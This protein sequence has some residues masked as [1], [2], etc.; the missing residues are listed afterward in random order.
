MDNNEQKQPAQARPEKIIDEFP[1]IIGTGE[2]D[3]NPDYSRYE[4]D[5][6]FSIYKVG[7]E[8]KST[9]LESKEKPLDFNDPNAFLIQTD[10]SKGGDNQH[11]VDLDF[12]LNQSPKATSKPTV[13]SDPTVSSAQSATA[14]EAAFTKETFAKNL[15]YAGDFSFSEDLKSSENIFDEK[16]DLVADMSA[17]IVSENS[18]FS[19]NILDLSASNVVESK[20]PVTL[21][22][23]NISFFLAEDSDLSTPTISNSQSIENSVINSSSLVS[24]ADETKI[25]VAPM[26]DDLHVSSSSTQRPDDNVSHDSLS[27][28]LD[29]YD[30]GDSPAPKKHSSVLDQD[31][32]DYVSESHFEANIAQPH[33]EQPEE[34]ILSKY[35][36]TSLIPSTIPE[37]EVVEEISTSFSAPVF[38]EKFPQALQ[39][40]QVTLSD[41]NH[42][43]DHEVDNTSHLIDSTGDIMKIK[44]QNELWNI[45]D[46]YAASADAIEHASVPLSSGEP[47][48]TEAKTIDVQ[49]QF[50]QEFVI[51]PSPAQQFK[52]ES[53]VEPKRQSLSDE[54]SAFQN[55]SAI[56]DQLYAASEEAPILATAPVMS[57]FAVP[58]KVQNIPDLKSASFDSFANMPAADQYLEDNLVEQKVDSPFAATN[59][60]SSNTLP[61]ET[62][63]VFTE[64]PV[65]AVDIKA[66]Q[67][68]YSDST[69]ADQPVAI[70][71]VLEEEEPPSPTSPPSA[72]TAVSYQVD[73]SEPSSQQ[74]HNSPQQQQQTQP[75]QL[76]EDLISASSSTNL[77]HTSSPANV[78]DQQQQVLS[79]LKEEEAEEEELPLPVQQ[80]QEKKSWSQDKAEASASV[81][82]A[83]TSA[84]V[85]SAVTAEK[86]ANTPE[87]KWSSSSAHTTAAAATT[88]TTNVEPNTRPSL[89]LSSSP[90]PD[91]TSSTSKMGRKNN[92]F[93]R[94]NSNDEPEYS[95][96]GKCFLAPSLLALLL[97]S[98]VSLTHALTCPVVVIV[99]YLSACIRG[100]HAFHCAFPL[101]GLLPLLLV[102]DPFLLFFSVSPLVIL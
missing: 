73:Y 95:G 8:S 15:G 40:E 6:H 16:L 7:D 55:Q 83:A 57:T 62:A 20:Q 77:L 98:N 21:E 29:E 26:E 99:S 47:T 44:Q 80:E 61:A 82:A 19:D 76:T 17:S 45:T 65:A 69:V 89:S 12:D 36:D 66:N 46:S 86:E 54:L 63:Q 50:V 79:S 64:Q 9:V 68:V 34:D 78:V 31:D 74:P 24:F 33:E 53:P 97:P 18:S 87:Q 13:S 41:S 3:A 102:F 27:K 93:R 11:Y 4:L 85:A 10:N 75:E 1:T 71:G 32:D 2:Q 43:S 5:S 91:T 101:L 28:I 94:E 100:M 37:E 92:Q 90:A 56:Q 70:A 23:T 58:P 22:S 84:P 39:A 14:E 38:M 72:S 42:E 67:S 49:E 96:P 60:D 59:V 52:E 30:L 88:S 48:I 81:A 35:L 51:D 25:Y